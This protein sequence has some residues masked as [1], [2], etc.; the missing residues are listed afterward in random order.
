MVKLFDQALEEKDGAKKIE[1]RAG[2]PPAACTLLVTPTEVI[3]V[4]DSLD[5][6]F[7]AGA[8]A[9]LKDRGSE[10]L[11]KG[12]QIDKFFIVHSKI[13]KIKYI[14]QKTIHLILYDK[15]AQS[16]R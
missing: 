14:S 16:Y 3:S 15:T 10:A 5:L 9:Y 2:S 7:V 4:R 11:L 13:T 8:A 1:P 6:S 12:I